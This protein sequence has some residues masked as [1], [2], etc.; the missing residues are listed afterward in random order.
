MTVR[1]FIYP[2]VVC[3]FA[4]GVSAQTPVSKSYL[5]GVAIGGVDT[6]A[7]FSAAEQNSTLSIEGDARFEFEWNEA[8]WRFADQASLDKFAEEPEKWVPEFN[9]YCANA[10]SL[11]E[12]LI[13]TDGTVWQ[14]FGDKL[15]LF[16][17]TRGLRRWQQGDWQTYLIE[18]ENAWAILIK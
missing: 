8:T 14:F 16:Y 3:L 5:T 9:G 18:A 17:A 6:V 10:L 12:G 11:G 13:R 4:V 7:Y 15:Y 2:L 1:N